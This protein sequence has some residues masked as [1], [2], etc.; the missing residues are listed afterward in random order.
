MTK[1]ATKKTK[2]KKRQ[3]PSKAFKPTAADLRSARQRAARIIQG[4][5]RL[6]PIA[7]TALD[8]QDAVQLLVAT[9]LSAQCTDERVN[10]VTKDL[11]QKYKNA[12]DYA[13]ADPAELE[14][15]IRSTGFYRN[16]A[17]NIR[18]CC[19]DLV[20][21]HGGKVP[22]TMEALTALAGVGRKTAN[23]VLGNCFGIPGVVTDTHVIRLSRLMGLSKHVDP[24]KLE[25]DLMGLF[26]E[27][28]WVALSH[29]LISHGRR[30]CVA[31]RPDCGNCPL[32]PECA[33]GRQQSSR[34]Q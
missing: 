13:K 18:T 17:K 28:D 20:D 31:R 4:L 30:V 25:F 11:F 7:E 14:Q 29:M 12:A 21:K 19:R 27:K 10:I 3:E 8:H 1:V 15:D 33:F 23:C 32:Q 2:G 6:Y 26:A 9:I 34:T 22:Q 5:Y 24:V 16:K